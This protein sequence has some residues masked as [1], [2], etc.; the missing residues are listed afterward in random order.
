M[1]W[2]MKTCPSP[3]LETE[4]SASL[5]KVL[6]TVKI[7]PT[8]VIESQ[9]DSLNEPFPVEVIPSTGGNPAACT[10]DWHDTSVKAFVTF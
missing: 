4:I 3:T 8:E 5:A 1:I 10:G 9:K 7:S 6:K 2:K